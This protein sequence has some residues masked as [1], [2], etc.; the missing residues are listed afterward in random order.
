MRFAQRVLKSNRSVLLYGSASRL[1]HSDKEEFNDS[2]S[3]RAEAVRR[4]LLKA[5]VE[6]EKIFRAW[7]GQDPPRLLARPI[8]K[9]L[10]YLPL[11]KR[12]NGL[13][14]IKYM[15]QNVMVVAW[16]PTDSSKDSKSKK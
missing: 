2:L 1:S 7:I 8:A 10:G 13:G 9:T 6:D 5:G 4:I 3:R 16:Q 14:L 11:W 15:D 12:L